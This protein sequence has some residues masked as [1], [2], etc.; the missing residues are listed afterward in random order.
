VLLFPYHIYQNWFWAGQL[1]FSKRNGIGRI[2]ATATESLEI[3]G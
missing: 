2:T 3:A 1:L